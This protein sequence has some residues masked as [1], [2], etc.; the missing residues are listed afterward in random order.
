MQKSGIIILQGKFEQ[1][2]FGFS[3]MQRASAL[4]ITG[5]FEYL[6]TDKVQ[7]QVAGSETAIQNFHLWCMSQKVT[8]SG[9]L[10]TL[11]ESKKYDEFQIINQL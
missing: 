8:L 11:S 2:G 3:C 7:I 9:N 6:T 5:Q 10:R 1:S 4:N